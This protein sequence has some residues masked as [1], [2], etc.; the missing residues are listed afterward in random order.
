MDLD[1]DL[2]F[3]CCGERWFVKRSMSLLKRI[4]QALGAVGPLSM[5]L[6][7]GQATLADVT[8]VYH[9]LLC[10][11][12]SAPARKEIEAWLFDA[13]LL[14]PSRSIAVQVYSLIVGNEALARI[15][16]GEEQRAR[17]KAEDRDGS[18][19]APTE[20]ATSATG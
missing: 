17:R 10:D 14:V 11:V 20:P 3:D 15:A 4:E 19:F 12:S 8:N 16:A 18:P 9:L 6:E 7:N 1:Y 13:G 5:R 2:A